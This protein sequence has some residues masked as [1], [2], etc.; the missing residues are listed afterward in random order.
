MASQGRT[1]YYCVMGRLRKW[2]ASHR[3]SLLVVTAAIIAIYFWLAN[4]G[5]LPQADV[6]RKGEYGP[7]DN[8][9]S[10][11]AVSALVGRALVFA[12]EHNGLFIA[13]F[14][15]TLW[16]S[17][18]LMWKASTSQLRHSENTAQRQLRAYIGIERVYIENLVVGQI[19]RGVIDIKNFGQTPAHR[20]DVFAYLAWYLKP[21]DESALQIPEARRSTESSLA[22]GATGHAYPNLGTEWTAELDAGLKGGM[23][24]L[25]I[26]G[27]IHYRDIFDQKRI[28][29]F[30]VYH[31][32]RCNPGLTHHCDTGNWQS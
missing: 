25:Y 13:A 9:A 28:T 12:D 23:L 26:F 15:G 8:C 7:P 24:T 27:E 29:S 16:F 3:I 30:R 20:Y 4:K 31:D 14:T 10:Y 22:P 18:H 1:Y 21:V 19:P 5:A 32:V 2:C 11:D 17:T 6:C